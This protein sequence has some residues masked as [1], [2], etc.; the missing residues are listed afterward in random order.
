MNVD[1][2]HD[3][4]DDNNYNNDDRKDPAY[5]VR[6]DSCHEHKQYVQ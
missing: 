3:D 5:R 4:D 6:T 2:K 1:V